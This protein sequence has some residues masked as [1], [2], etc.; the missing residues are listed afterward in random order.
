MFSVS[1]V[2]VWLLCIIPRDCINFEFL[3]CTLFTIVGLAN[4]FMW[5]SVMYNVPDI[6]GVQTLRCP[7]FGDDLRVKYHAQEKTA[8]LFM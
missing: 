6:G 7:G 5:M 3:S 1:I 4:N 2:V 8:T